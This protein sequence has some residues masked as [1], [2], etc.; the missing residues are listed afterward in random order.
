MDIHNLLQLQ[1]P[2]DAIRSRFKLY[3]DITPGGAAKCID[4]GQCEARCTQH[5]PIIERL[6]TLAAFKL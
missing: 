5:L 6:K 4:C 1:M 2:P 3:W